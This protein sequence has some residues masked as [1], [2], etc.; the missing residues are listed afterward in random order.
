MINCLYEPITSN[1]IIEDNLFLSDPFEGINNNYF[2]NEDFNTI[3]DH[4]FDYDMETN[5]NEQEINHSNDNNQINNIINNNN[6]NNNNDNN[7]NSNNINNNN[8][9]IS[10]N[11]NNNS[12]LEF[13]FEPR[14]RGR[15]KNIKNK[16]TKTKF[17]K[18]LNKDSDCC[19]ICLQEFKNNQ[20]IYKLS[21][22]H[23]FHI[24]CLNKEIKYRQKCPTCRKK[25]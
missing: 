12:I 10:N 8:N 25:F 19:I 3:I 11:I 18:A 5:S 1:T 9:I 2:F 13:R 20:K 6:I 21:C 15:N 4:Q 17:I 22:N 23:I 24:R 16:L 7:T 14:N